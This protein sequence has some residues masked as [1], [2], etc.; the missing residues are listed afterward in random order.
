MQPHP[1][2]A[3]AECTKI[4]STSR[5]H[6]PSGLPTSHHHAPREAQGCSP[7][8]S[9]LVAHL[10]PE[11]LAMHSMSRASVK[12]CLVR[13]EID[14]SNHTAETWSS[15]ILLVGK[16]SSSGVD[17]TT[18]IHPHTL[19]VPLPSSASRALSSPGAL[20]TCKAKH[21]RVQRWPSQPPLE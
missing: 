8:P 11:H 4:P 9:R 10:R 13:A 7:T 16:K 15:W 14:I 18:Y 21:T 17:S 6:H 2:H 19:P 1:Q 20:P 12:P 3:H 5:R